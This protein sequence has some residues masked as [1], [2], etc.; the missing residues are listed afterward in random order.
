M[1]GKEVKSVLKGEYKN[2]K[3]DNYMN[4]LLIHS[5]LTMDM[6]AYLRA[7]N[8]RTNTICDTFEDIY[9]HQSDEELTI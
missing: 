8:L 7:R 1:I 4:D 9:M 6:S 3:L 2:P 5:I